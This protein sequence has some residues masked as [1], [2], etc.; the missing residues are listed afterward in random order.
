MAGYVLADSL[1]SPEGFDMKAIFGGQT[2]IGPLDTIGGGGG[3]GGVHGHG[4]PHGGHAHT[5]SSGAMSME[6]VETSSG[7]PFGL[8][9]M[10]ASGMMGIGMSGLGNTTSSGPFM[11]GSHHHHQH[12]NNM[13]VSNNGNGNGNNG[14]G[15]GVSVMMT[16]KTSPSTGSGEGDE[17]EDDDLPRGRKTTRFPKQE[18]ET[19][20]L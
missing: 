13:L 2:G 20:V 16:D 7:Q 1:N 17:A 11:Q 8:S 3:G 6:G 19:P 15:L 10:G 14:G 5:L 4:N 9:S 12:N 18:D